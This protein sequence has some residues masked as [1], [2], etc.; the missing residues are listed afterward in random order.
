M[1][2]ARCVQPLVSWSLSWHPPGGMLP[3]LASPLNP[4]HHRSFPSDRSGGGQQPVS[5]FAPVAQLI[6]QS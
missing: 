2:L 5:E 1:S 6:R 3:D 4:I